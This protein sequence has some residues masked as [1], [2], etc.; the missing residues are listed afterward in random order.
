MRV[1]AVL[2]RHS[3]GLALKILNEKC[4]KWFAL[5]KHFRPSF[6]TASTDAEDPSA[7]H[8]G[9]VAPF[10]FV[11]LYLRLYRGIVLKASRSQAVHSFFQKDPLCQ[12][13][14]YLDIL[15]SQSILWCLHPK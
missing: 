9:H 7:K 15:S 13:D 3:P 8:G 11:F 1:L 12:I 5:V 6:V 2:F 4:A 10:G 14:Q